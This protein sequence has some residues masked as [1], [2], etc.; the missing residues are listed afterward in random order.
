MVVLCRILEIF[1][2][3]ETV[4]CSLAFIPFHL[5][6]MVDTA[7]FLLFFLF[8]SVHSVFAFNVLFTLC[9]AFTLSLSLARSL[10]SAILC[11]YM[12][13]M[14][15]EY[16]PNQ[17]NHFVRIVFATFALQVLLIGFHLCRKPKAKSSSSTSCE[18]ICLRALSLT[19]PHRFSFVTGFDLSLWVLFC[20]KPYQ[21]SIFGLICVCVC[22]VLIFT[23]RKEKWDVSQIKNVL[24]FDEGIQLE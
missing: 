12:R 3:Y 9:L 21:P 7:Q 8:C 23:D 17:W 6:K 22:V 19:H 4:K 1:S 14:I 18:C 10:F 15:I 2:R 11:C 16:F 20:T 24:F 5:E 13:F